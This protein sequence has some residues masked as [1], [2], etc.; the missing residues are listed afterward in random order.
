MCVCVCV[1]PLGKE[2]MYRSVPASLLSIYRS[3]GLIG[4]LYKGLT[5]NWIKGPIAAAV[6]FGLFEF[7]QIQLRHLKVFQTCERESGYEQKNL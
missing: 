3:E 7:I 5:L 1:G 6:V 2:D 4:G